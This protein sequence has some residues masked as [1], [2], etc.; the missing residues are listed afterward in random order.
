MAK[1]FG[2]EALGLLPSGNLGLGA[3]L[4]SP[5][6]FAHGASEE[7]FWTQPCGGRGGSDVFGSAPAR[8]LGS[9]AHRPRQ[10]RSSAGASSFEESSVTEAFRA[11]SPEVLAPP[12]SLGSGRR[13]AEAAAAGGP[14]V[15][16][17]APQSLGSRAARSSQHRSS[18]G[19][20][21]FVGAGDA[22]G[23]DDTD[24]PEAK[25]PEEQAQAE[26]VH[27]SV[28]K[29]EMIMADEIIRQGK[30]TKEFQ[31][32]EKAGDAAALNLV[33]GCKKGSLSKFIDC[34]STKFEALLK[35]KYP[36]I[37]E[38]A[39]KMAL[40]ASI[41]ASK[42][43]GEHMSS[44]DKDK[45]EHQEEAAAAAFVGCLKQE[46]RMVLQAKQA[47]VKDEEF[48]ALDKFIR[49]LNKEQSH[50]KVDPSMHMAQVVEAR[51]PVFM[52]ERLKS[53]ID[54][55]KLS[56]EA[57][58]LCKGIHNKCTT[59]NAEVVEPGLKNGGIADGLSSG[60][61]SAAAASLLALAPGC[62]RPCATAAA[63]AGSTRRRMRTS[64]ERRG[65]EACRPCGASVSS[66]RRSR[67]ALSQ[68]FD[69]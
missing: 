1:L 24:A 44:A 9:R 18:A 67:A 63:A 11:A 17:R 47:L 5:A 34:I 19:A 53:K 61:T 14:D 22:N 4:R 62:G 60:L 57:N 13:R 58:K 36:A 21:S 46:M 48:D 64:G 40:A 39:E 55:D 43:A 41:D 49:D 51:C 10:H 45:E 15:F 35:D 25:T 69:L 3:R 37:R 2:A 33:E 29:G 20:S 68:F 26:E 12:R 6:L 32:A 30:A 65:S 7:T 27:E 42:H 50:L 8:S 52:S 54:E 28:E 66:G 31:Q 23:A 56:D 16:G 38:H 59:L